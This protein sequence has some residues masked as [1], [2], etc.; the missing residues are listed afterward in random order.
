MAFIELPDGPAGREAQA[1]KADAQLIVDALNAYQP[2][3][4]QRSRQEGI[5]GTLRKQLDAPAN[6]RS[7]SP[8]KPKQPGKKLS[9]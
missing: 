3:P 7:S 4:P 5:R 8:R 6:P 9:H 1:A 2:P